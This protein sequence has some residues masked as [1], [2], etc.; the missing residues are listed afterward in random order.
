MS[1]R[2]SIDQ[3]FTIQEYTKAPWKEGEVI[4]GGNDEII[5]VG[6]EFDILAYYKDEYDELL[7][8]FEKTF[9][10]LEID[11]PTHMKRKTRIEKQFYRKF[12]RLSKNVHFFGSYHVIWEDG[13]KKF[14][15]DGDVIISSSSIGKLPFTFSEVTGEFKCNGISL[16]SLE[17]SPKKVGK[18]FFCIGNKLFT[19]QGAPTEVSGDF[20]C[21]NNEL[22]SLKGAPKKVGGDFQC[23]MNVK[24]T[25]LEGAPTEVGKNF[26]CFTLR[27]TTLEGAPQRV[28][29]YFSCV[30]NQY[31]ISLEGAPKHARL[32][33]CRNCSHLPLEEIEKLN[34]QVPY[35]VKH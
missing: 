28:G 12:S 33:D 29:G 16:I 4:T 27:I 32:L 23:S 26:E 30:N 22:I 2:E 20:H 19:L 15:V 25:S 14:K 3:V 34:K 31:L 1:I 7:S 5:T 11:N 8:K 35:L 17:G 21:Y 6:R 24:L 10:T 18:D 9:G 13:Q